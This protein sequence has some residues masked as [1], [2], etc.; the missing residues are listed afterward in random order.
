MLVVDVIFRK[1]TELGD[2]ELP[3]DLTELLFDSK[4]FRCSKC[5]L[6]LPLYLLYKKE[7]YIDIFW[8]VKCYKYSC[9]S[10]NVKK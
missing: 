6:R 2:E 8:G 10:C 5:E 9:I 7:H 4:L 3:V 1:S